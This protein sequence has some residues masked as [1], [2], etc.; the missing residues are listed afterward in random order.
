MLVFASECWP[1][2]I[3]KKSN[4]TGYTA[5]PGSGLD[6]LNPLHYRL[7]TTVLG[8]PMSYQ[9]HLAIKH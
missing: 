2:E 9:V 5:E 4:Q 1:S 6:A 8:T 7:N 3:R